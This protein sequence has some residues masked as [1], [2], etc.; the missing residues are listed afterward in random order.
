VTGHENE[1]SYTPKF[2][3]WGLDRTRASAEA[4]VPLVVE[5]VR[6]RSVVDFGCGLGVWLE[7]FARHGV[8]DYVGV[9]GPWVPQEALRLAQDHFVTARLDETL[10]LG[11]R[12]DLAVAL[13][14]AEHL[15]EH[16]AKA[17]VRNLVEH[18]PCVLFSAAVPHQGGTDH[19]N[20]QWP[21]YWAEHFA[22]HDFAVVDGI[23]PVIWSNPAVLPFY[24][25]NVLLFAT[26]SYIGERPLLARDRE[27]TVEGQL[28]LVHPELMESIAAHPREHV[29]RPAA[30][31]LLLSELVAALPT[32]LARSLRWRLHRAA[33]QIARRAQP[34]R[35]VSGRAKR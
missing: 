29:R 32:V 27:R 7:T 34:T 22:A 3:A 8:D 28:S 24:R 18:A 2:F 11:R 14:V 13:E 25:Q 31:E 4:I 23:R 5:R 15:P 16:R 33:E 35:T 12:F 10:R 1:T 17:F 19:L 30:R 26:A 6:P 9:D 21:N 20:E